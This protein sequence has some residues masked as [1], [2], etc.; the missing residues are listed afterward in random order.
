MRVPEA[1]TSRRR[2]PRTPVLA[3]VLLDRHAD[4]VAPL[5]PRAVVVLD[6]ADA[7]QLVQHEPRV[8]R[9]LADAAVGDDRR[10]AVDDALA[11]L[12]GAQLVGRLERAVPR[13]RLAPWH[14][15][16]AR[17]VT[18]AL[19]ALLLVAGHRDQ[20]AAEL[21]RGAHVD[22]VHV[23]LERDE[24]LVPVRAERLGAWLRDEAPRLEARDLG[25]R[26]AALADPLLAR[27]V[28]Q[29]DVLV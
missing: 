4:Q 1:R 20:L 16:R 9:A 2:R 14:G 28:E 6:V 5:G 17:D 10:G 22:E 26:R 27:A 15:C 21:L 19:G 12:E 7:E 18:A 13:D 24:H 23:A 11:G 29:L 25:G 3:D 8:R